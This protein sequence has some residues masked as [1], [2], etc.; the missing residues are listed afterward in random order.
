MEE[1]GS[2]KKL[3]RRDP[4]WLLSYADLMSLLFAMFVVLLSF[5]HTDKATFEQKAAPIAKAFT[6][7]PPERKATPPTVQPP[8]TSNSIL[9]FTRPIEQPDEPEIEEKIER[10]RQINE[11]TKKLE[12]IL[13]DELKR[14]E[15]DLIKSDGMVTI[16]FRDRA[17]FSPGDRELSPNILETL[18]GIASVL[19]RTPGRIRIEGHTDDIPISTGLFRSNWD[20]AAARAAS[21]VHYLLQSGVID[22]KRISAEGFADSR[23]LKPNDTVEG[24]ASN[25]RVE[26]VIEMHPTAP[27]ATAPAAP[28][29]ATGGAPAR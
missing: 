29:P 7:V 6:D 11:L 28:P 12:I 22:P 13:A 15:V 25:R 9:D 24:R 1:N 21:V 16:R 14:E 17:A 3:T 8:S 26:I 23:P 5:S 20:L 2:F 19:G 27:A 4:R 10:T 18:D